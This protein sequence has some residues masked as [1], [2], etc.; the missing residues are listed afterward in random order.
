MR[1]MLRSL[2]LERDEAYDVIWE[3]FE[4]VESVI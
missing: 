2:R 1:T 4:A 3:M